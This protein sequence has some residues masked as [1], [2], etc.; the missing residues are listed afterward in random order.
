MNFRFRQDWNWPL[1]NSGP[2]PQIFEF[3][4]IIPFVAW[5][6]V[7]LLRVTVRYDIQGSSGHGLGNVQI[8]DLVVF[9][10]D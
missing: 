4:P 7:N 3:R 5:D 6:Q 9:D 1:S 2:E 8:S 10:A